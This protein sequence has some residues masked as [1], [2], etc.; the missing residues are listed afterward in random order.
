MCH[1]FFVDPRYVVLF[2]M[3]F[4]GARDL[5]HIDV[6]IYVAPFINLT[7]MLQT[8]LDYTCICIFLSFLTTENVNS[9]ASVKDIRLQICFDA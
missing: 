3:H 4:S 1:Y 2:S 9:D 6:D 8:F 5:L 7:N